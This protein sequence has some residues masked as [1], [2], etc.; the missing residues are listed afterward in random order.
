MLI[1]WAALNGCLI[2]T[3][4]CYKGSEKKSRWLV[5]EEAWADMEKNFRAYVWP[6][7]NMA[8]FRYF[9]CPLTAT[10]NDWTTLVAKIWKARKKWYRISSII[11]R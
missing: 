9:G 3:D 10:D 5:V 7:T 6:L 8:L 11:A 4:L 1:A 2:N